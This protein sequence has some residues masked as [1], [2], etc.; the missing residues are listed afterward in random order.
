MKVQEEFIENVK[1]FAYDTPKTAVKTAAYIAGGVCGPAAMACGLALAKGADAA[2]D[3]RK[4]REINQIQ[5]IR[6]QGPLNE[7]IALP[8]E[9]ESKLPLSFHDIDLSYDITTNTTDLVNSVTGILLL[10]QLMI[11]GHPKGK[12]Y[13]DEICSSSYPTEYSKVSFH[14]TKKFFFKTFCLRAVNSV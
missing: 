12:P 14:Y 10:V 6:C 4:K 1:A 2:W 7:N 9:L 5:G 3:A 13:L 11:S 8:Q